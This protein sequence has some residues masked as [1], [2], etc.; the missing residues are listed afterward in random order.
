MKRTKTTERINS[1][2]TWSRDAGHAIR[3]FTHYVQL[4]KVNDRIFSTNGA[5]KQAN[6]KKSP[7]R[8]NKRPS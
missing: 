8:R 2:V 1:G 3:K 7:L 6:K 4:F 5:I